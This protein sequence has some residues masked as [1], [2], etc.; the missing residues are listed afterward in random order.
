[1]RYTST[2][3]CPA[4]SRIARTFSDM[5]STPRTATACEAVKEH[6]M[7]IQITFFLIYI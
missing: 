7:H 1:M 4:S 6:F 2:S 3:A 5:K